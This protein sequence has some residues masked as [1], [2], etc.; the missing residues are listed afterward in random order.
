M[1]LAVIYSP[2]RCSY[3]ISTFYE[4]CTCFMNHD[5][6]K[7]EF[8]EEGFLLNLADWNK[9]IS[10]KIAATEHIRLTAAH[11]EIIYLLREFY[12]EFGLSPAMRIFVKHVRMRLGQEKGSSQYL[13][14][15]FPGSP[16]KI[17]SKIAGLPKPTNCL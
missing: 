16:T 13:L 17:C 8:D 9:L 1:A 7:I 5:L 14:S 2:I 3:P 15:L 6:S 11:W 4:L 12:L 10:E